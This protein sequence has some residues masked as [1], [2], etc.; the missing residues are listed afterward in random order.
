MRYATDEHP[1]DQPI[2]S[3]VYTDGFGTSRTVEVGYDGVTRIE[4]CFK[5]GLH[6][7]IPYVRVWVGD[8]C[9][10]EFCQHNIDGVFFASPPA[11]DKEA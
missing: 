1:V 4:A 2:S 7:N 5:S 3:F 10:S 8:E 6:A 9:A 11:D